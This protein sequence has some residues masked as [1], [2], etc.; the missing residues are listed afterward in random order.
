MFNKSKTIL[1]AVTMAALIVGG[2][3][4]AAVADQRG[5]RQGP[6]MFDF[7]QADA[8]ADGKVTKDEI[9]AFHSAQIAAMDTDNDGNISEA[10]MIA[11]HEQRKA[12]RQA[13]GVK[14]MMER[15]DAND[16]GVVSLAEMAPPMD[17]G[18]KMFDRVD[19]D[20]DGA[21]SKAEADAA[22]EKMS[23]RKGNGGHKGKHDRKGKHDDN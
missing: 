11:A 9:A 14:R 6:P 20:G 22:K 3:S 12:E 13:R 10:E 16:D 23:K 2:F 1:S 8:N 18:D 7:A 15:M 4:T 5:D 17:R 19:T 21:I